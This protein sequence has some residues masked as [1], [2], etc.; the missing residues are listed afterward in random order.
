V[1]RLLEA[2]RERAVRVLGEQ[3]VDRFLST[4]HP[5]IRWDPPVL[6]IDTCL[7]IADQEAHLEGRGLVL[8]P[9]VFCPPG[10]P[11]CAP[12][13]DPDASPV[14][15]YPVALDIGALGE[16]WGS[17]DQ[18][19]SA[20]AAGSSGSGSGSGSSRSSSLAALLGRTRAAVLDAVA[21]GPCTTSELAHRAGVSVPSASEHAAVLRSADL[22]AT[23]RVGKAVLHTVTPLG[24]HLLDPSP[25]S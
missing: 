1:A 17:A 3:G 8:V 21:A 5:T 7:P 10:Y 15:H 24:A 6:T 25:A 16:L 20:G 11:M 4:C 9:S 19:R 14:I 13:A 12:A 22:I 23:R 18:A 2:E